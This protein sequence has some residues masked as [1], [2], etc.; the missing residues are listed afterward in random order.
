MPA[1]PDTE[2]SVA[3]V[4]LTTPSTRSESRRVMEQIERSLV[5]LALAAAV[6]LTVLATYA[7]QLLSTNWSGLVANP[8]AT[9]VRLG[10][11]AALFALP[12]V[13]APGLT[14]LADFAGRPV[15]LNFWAT[16][17]GPCRTEMPE[18]ERFQQQA[19]SSATVVGVD[20][21]EDAATVETFLRQYGI[22]YR[23][24]LDEDGRVAARYGVTG[25]PT[26]VFVD[27][28]GVARDRVVGPLTFD[29]LV[30]RTNRLP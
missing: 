21:Q 14:R 23:I 3:R 5:W 26:S 27:R 9:T 24:A 18:F 29:G 17:C 16:W 28:S 19:G 8:E 30:Q 6:A 25:L 10:A 22:T 20:L 13:P 11:P 2:S 4:P 15:L 1:P 12:S 7:E